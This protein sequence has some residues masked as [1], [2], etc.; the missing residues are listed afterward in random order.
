MDYREV[1][2]SNPIESNQ[3]FYT[4]LYQL[5]LPFN[6][7]FLPFLSLSLKLQMLTTSVSGGCF[8]RNELC[9]KDD[10]EIFH[11]VRFYFHFEYFKFDHIWD[12][13][14]GSNLPNKKLLDHQNLESFK[15][16]VRAYSSHLSC[17]TYPF[18]ETIHL[19][20]NN[21]NQHCTD[22]VKYINPFS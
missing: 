8:A 22:I 14:P 20:Q 11:I 1:L 12:D 13:P 7:L 15:I 21:N 6:Q 18:L 17:I 4:N 10:D 5:F 2:G 16:Q 9:W 3:Y 19:T